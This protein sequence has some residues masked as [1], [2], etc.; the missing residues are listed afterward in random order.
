MN[1]SNKEESVMKDIDF[2]LTKSLILEKVKHMFGQIRDRLNEISNDSDLNT[3]PYTRGKISKG[4]NYRQLPY[5]VLDCPAEFNGNHI[6]TYRIMFWWGHFF[7]ATIHLQGDHLEKYRDAIV[8]NI[9]L[10]L[11]RDVYIS[12]GHTPWEYHYGNDNYAPLTVDH[13]S[14]IRDCDFLK[15]SQKYELDN[16]QSVPIEVVQ[17]YE[18]LLVVLES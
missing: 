12:I 2:L 1:F 9:T 17:F 10:L 18:L 6:F 4:E 3:S 15:L 8:K 11:E 5:L 13:E 16:W 14:H 7:S